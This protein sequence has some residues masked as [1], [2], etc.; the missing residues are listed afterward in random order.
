MLFREVHGQ[1]HL[2]F[3]KD[4][5]GRRTILTDFPVFVF[6]PVPAVKNQS[7]N[8]G[9]LIGAAIVMALTLLLWP[10]NAMLRWHY[11][12][13]LE[14]TPQYRRLRWWMRLV[15]VVDLGFLTAFG[16]WLSSVDE[17]IALLGSRFDP[18][19][20]AMQVLGL[21]GVLG[22]VI[23]INYCVRSWAADGLWFWTRV[24]NTL[25]MLACVGYSFFLLN[26]HVLN[27]RLNY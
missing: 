20:H 9:V 25:L 10:L 15:C 7:L 19:L 11:R 1:S 22:T 13:D 8:L 5:A 6:Q 26:W 12:Y 17:N 4:Y 27:F 18:K 24:W 3:L 23:A 14:L 2:A 16:L 21:L